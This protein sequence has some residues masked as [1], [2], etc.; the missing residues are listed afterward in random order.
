M[1]LSSD[2]LCTVQDD[3]LFALPNSSSLANMCFSFSDL[4]RTNILS[5]AEKSVKCKKFGSV[6]HA[7]N[8]IGVFKDILEW[9]G[10]RLNTNLKTKGNL[11]NT[12]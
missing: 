11:F 12:K 3:C 7:Y 6:L 2:R 10:H 4:I 9:L 5:G 1:N 8:S